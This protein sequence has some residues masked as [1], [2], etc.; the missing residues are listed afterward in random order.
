MMEMNSWA[1]S[2]RLFTEAGKQGEL[3][4]RHIRH[5]LV[6]V[7]DL[8]CQVGCHWIIVRIIHV[9]HA[10]PNHAFQCPIMEKRSR[11]A[12]EGLDMGRMTRNS[13]CQ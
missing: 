11:D 4:R 6:I 2:Y 7:D 9:E 10:R 5:A 8:R 1:L 3:L 12:R 13:V